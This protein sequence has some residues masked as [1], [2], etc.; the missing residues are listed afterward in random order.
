M[1]PHGHL[2]QTLVGV[3]EP[4]IIRFSTRIFDQTVQVASFKP[5]IAITNIET[6]CIRAHEF[7]ILLKVL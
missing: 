2:L 3:A 1:A 5:D 6:L 7:E 4:F